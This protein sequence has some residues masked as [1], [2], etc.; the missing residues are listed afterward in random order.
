MVRQS[1]ALL[2]CIVEGGY[3]SLLERARAWLVS[4]VAVSSFSAI[5][6]ASL[7]LHLL[8]LRVLLEDTVGIFFQIISACSQCRRATNDYSNL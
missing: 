7:G 5:D 4:L 2:S 6:S 8:D 3:A 1:P